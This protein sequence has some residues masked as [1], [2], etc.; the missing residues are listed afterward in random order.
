MCGKEERIWRSAVVGAQ[1]YAFEVSR[2]VEW[3]EAQKRMEPPDAGYE[4]QGHYDVMIEVRCE[5][6]IA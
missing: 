4:L 5:R 2:S 1:R 6:V 3:D